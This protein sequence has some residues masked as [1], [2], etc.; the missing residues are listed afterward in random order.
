MSTKTTLK[1]IAL[2]AVSALGFGLFTAVSPANA[3]VITP[4]AVAAGTVPTHR[5]GVFAET[6]IT[7]THPAAASDTA[8]SFTV[9][10]RV[11]SAPAT[12]T[13]YNN[14][15][16][17]V[18]ASA[19]RLYF[20]AAAG[21]VATNGDNPSYTAHTNAATA[22]YDVQV[23]ETFVVGSTTA[24]S[25][26]VSMFFKADV[27]GSY[28]VLVSAGGNGGTFY[29]AGQPTAVV[30]IT[31]GGVPASVTATAINATSVESGNAAIRVALADAA[32]NPTVLGVDEVLNLTEDCTATVTDKVDGSGTA[33]DSGDMVRGYGWVNLAATTISAT[34]TC[35][36]TITGSGTLP[37]TLTSNVT[38]TFRDDTVTEGAISIYLLSTLGGYE[39]G[40]ISAEN[41]SLEYTTAN[42]SHTFAVAASAG[43]STTATTYGRVTV[44]DTDGIITGYGSS[45]TLD[46]PVTYAAAT[47]ALTTANITIAADL[48]ETLTNSFKIGTAGTADQI[49]IAGEA[50]VKTSVTADLVTVRTAPAS[51]VVLYATVYDQYG[52]EM[53]NQ[54]V[55]VA[56]TG[57]NATTATI[58]KSSDADG[59]VSYS[60]TDTGTTGNSTVT[61]TATGTDS[62]TIIWAEA[63]VGTVTVTGG[64][65]ANTVAYPAVGSTTKAISTGATGAGASTT[66]FTATVKDASGNLLSGVPVTWSVDSATAG[67][68][69]T[70][71]SDSSVCYT[72]TDGTCTTTVYSWAAPSKVTVTATAGGKTGTGYEN[73]V[74]ASTDAR[75]L[76][77]TVNGSI[78]TAK[79]VDRYGNVVAGVSVS[80]ITDKGYF[81]SGVTSTTG[82]TGTDGTVGFVLLGNSDSASVTLSVDSAVYTQTDDAAGKVGTTA[83]TAAVAGTSTGVGSSLAPVGVNKVVSTVAASTANASADAAADAAAEA[84]DAANAATDAANLA[85]EAADAATVAAEEARDAADA[86]T[87]A[88]EE[89]ATQVATL[90]AALKAQITTLA[91]TVAKIA[92]K[93][94]A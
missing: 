92:K 8:D 47:T 30:T 94:K 58:T 86:A 41:T 51:T 2:V 65:T 18:N 62:V 4:T 7:I 84:I 28:Q 12:S 83:V 17:T 35:V 11:I 33:I 32:G 20:A 1:R 26:T 54:S 49:G 90:M 52:I 55:T 80:A 91:N 5:I 38:V 42:T 48:A 53:A 37:S 87:A 10:A 61:F 70:A 46:Y 66:T 79:M 77:A 29:V 43:T 6:P 57:R 88:V 64:A 74:N 78:V 22:G 81:G 76:S 73:F 69:K 44:T 60:L 50:P 23:S 16:N 93:V 82:T 13:L 72:S 19:A 45:W 14:A 15:T 40:A 3:A 9:H 31:T 68:T 75:V 71:T 24:T 56:V 59:R 21:S 36:V 85:A 27:A 25:T 39:S 63:V 89:L 34:E 67:I